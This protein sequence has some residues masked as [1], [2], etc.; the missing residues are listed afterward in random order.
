MSEPNR[1]IA[2]AVIALRQSGRGCVVGCSGGLDS[3]VL[4]H[5]LAAEL[6]GDLVVAFFDHGWRDASEDEALVRA[7]CTRLGLELVVGRSAPDPALLDAVGPEAEARQRRLAFLE[8]VARDRDSLVCL[9]HHLDDQAE[10]AALG[11]P[12][13]VRPAMPAARGPFRRPLLG[14]PKAA[15]AAWARAHDVAWVNDPTNIDQ[16]FERNRVRSQLPADPA[17]RR[18]LVRQALQAR[19]ERDRHTAAAHAAIAE[20][21]QPD[22][23]LSRAQLAALDEGT[24]LALLRQLCPPPLAGAR[25][26]STSALKAVLQSARRHGSRRQHHLGAGWTARIGRTLITL[27]P[28]PSSVCAPG[29]AGSQPSDNGPATLRYT[30]APSPSG[31]SRALEPTA[32]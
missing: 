10:N 31:F 5:L 3:S 2:H 1:A 4:C 22:G 14:V 29:E 8:G 17:L 12:G 6:G 15:L 30:G 20:I 19:G 32:S 26:P 9:G 27:N 7:M 21:V 16:R 28:A 24:A 18:S 11:A 13:A 23:T 25:G